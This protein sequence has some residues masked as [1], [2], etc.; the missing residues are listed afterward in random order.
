MLGKSIYA[1]SPKTGV[2]ALLFLEVIGVITMEFE[3]HKG[4][5]ITEAP[6][7]MFKAVKIVA[8]PYFKHPFKAC[9]LE[10]LKTSLDYALR[11]M[12]HINRYKPFNN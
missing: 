11:K 7:W 5:M 3:E 10:S 6:G 1:H 4:F 9:T 8:S 2:W 12:K